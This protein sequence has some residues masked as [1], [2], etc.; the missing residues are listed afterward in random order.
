MSPPIDAS[1]S[2]CPYNSQPA[3]ASVAAERDSLLKQKKSLKRDLE[4][5][6]INRDK[7]LDWG[8]KLHTELQ[9][10]RSEIAK[11]K[12]E[13][14]TLRKQVPTANRQG[15]ERVSERKKEA[16][17]TEASWSSEKE[18]GCTNA[19]WDREKKPANITP[20]CETAEVDD[21]VSW[22]EN[23]VDNSQA[24][25][26]LDAEPTNR[27]MS[28][29]SEPEDKFHTTNTNM[30]DKVTNK[31]VSWALEKEPSTGSDEESE[32]E[33]M[34]GDVERDNGDVSYW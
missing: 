14:T 34:W 26:S 21:K 33:P 2:S 23:E 31:K 32:S 4:L 8:N 24:D 3:I 11:L 25:W 27:R 22:G 19:D 10:A 15:R 30:E 7:Y 13:L 20:S 6:Q 28:W 16:A 9:A 18:V 29:N 1:T 5:L 17:D 12:T